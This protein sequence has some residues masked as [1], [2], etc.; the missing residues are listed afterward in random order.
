MI[1]RREFITLLGGAAAAW[2]VAARAQQVARLPTIGFFS[3]NTR[4]VASPWT[5]AFVERLHEVGWIEG[6]TIAI[7]YRWGE[8]RGDRTAEVISEFVRLNPDVIVT[9]GQSNIVAAK[10]ATSAIPI[11][12][13]L[14]TDPVAS[15]FVASL[16]RPGGNAT[17]LS[18]Q[19]TDLVGKRL[20][21]LREVVPSLRRL[22]IMSDFR[23]PEMAEAE[24][25]ARMLGLEVTTLPLRKPEDITSAFGTLKGT[26]D[27]L[28]VGAD[29]L[30][31]SSRVR[32][33]I[34]ALG[35]RLPT[36]H[37]FREA[38]EVGALLS[39]GPNFADLFRRAADYVD[40][41]L[42]G[43]KP[44]ELPVE[45]PTRFDLVINLTT[46]TAL[47]LT[48]PEAFLLRADEVIE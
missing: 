18:I 2:P 3:P 27:A 42:R 25:A 19:G 46:A 12:F 1:R 17:G 36:M 34:L 41:I 40:K 30:V 24:A 4:S 31:N 29:P 22:A 43:M 32:I 28:Y 38:V 39:Y 20:E 35:A 45:Q 9:H 47:G 15:G 33:N 21:L 14:A 7:E 23:N 26:A 13:A 16:A 10:E 48:I 8:G 44:A 37:G 6:R 11:V 5:A